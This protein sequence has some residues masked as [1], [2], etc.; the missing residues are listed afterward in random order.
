MTDTPR[1]T[2][3]Q[4]AHNTAVYRRRIAVWRGM[5]MRS[6]HFAQNAMPEWMVAPMSAGYW[7]RFGIN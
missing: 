6:C 7:R 3:A 2:P 5:L 1:L 4:R